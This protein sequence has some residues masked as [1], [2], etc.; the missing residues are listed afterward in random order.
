MFTQHFLALVLTLAAFVLLTLITF[1]VPFISNFY[2]LWTSEAGGVRFGIWGWCL[3]NAHTCLNPKQWG[4]AWDPQLIPWLLKGLILF[5]IAAGI[6]L[7]AILSIVPLLFS[8]HPHRYYP[9][10]MFSFFAL[11]GWLASFLAALDVGVLFGVGMHRFHK[12]GFSAHFGPLLWMAIGAAVA[13]TIVALSSGCGMLCRGR[14]G[15][16]YSSYNV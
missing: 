10:P 13:M 5:P 9:P 8:Y 11:A 16:T 3:D 2:F 14:M 7:L 15:R 12:D 1:S 6:C 4:Y